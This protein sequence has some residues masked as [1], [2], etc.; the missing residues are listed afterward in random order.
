MDI[1]IDSTGIAEQ[2]SISGRQPDQK[3]K[4]NSSTVFKSPRSSIAGA[5]VFKGNGT[6]F[7][8]NSTSFKGNSTSFKGNSMSFKGNSTSFKGNSVVFKSPRSSITVADGKMEE[9]VGAAAKGAVGYKIRAAYN[10][11]SKRHRDAVGGTDT[12]GYDSG[13]AGVLLKRQ[14]GAMGRDDGVGDAA[15]GYDSWSVGAARAY[16]SWLRETVPLKH[17]RGALGTDISVRGVAGAVGGSS[18]GLSYVNTA[19]LV[20][21]QNTIEVRIHLSI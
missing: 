19:T 3:V 16:D 6:V 5:T 13:D 7:K 20:Q 1:D 17:R 12:M 4:G 9:A 10:I 15:G 11:P 14:R 2:R 18:V 8:G 21:L